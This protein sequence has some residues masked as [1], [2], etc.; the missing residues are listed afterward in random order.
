MTVSGVLV[1]GAN[2]RLCSAPA[3]DNNLELV[4]IVTGCCRKPNVN[5]II[6]IGVNVKRLKSVSLIS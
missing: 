3:A 1:F 5:V 6:E 2:D 4:I